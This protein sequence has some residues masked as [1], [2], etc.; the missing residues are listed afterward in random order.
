[1]LGGPTGIKPMLGHV[2]N[3]GYVI[4]CMS[5]QHCANPF[6]QFRFVIASQAEILA[7]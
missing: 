5:V 3:G 2:H 4:M 6:V 1:M 7:R